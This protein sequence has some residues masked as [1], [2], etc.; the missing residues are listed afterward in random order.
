MLPSTP[1]DPMRR[2]G[3]PDSDAR[4]SE[5]HR[6]ASASTSRGHSPV[7]CPSLLAA[8]GFRDILGGR[9]RDIEEEEKPSE[10]GIDRIGRAGSG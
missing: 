2:D 6:E 10:T 8:P 3:R 1:D 7:G 9:K 5:E 4:G